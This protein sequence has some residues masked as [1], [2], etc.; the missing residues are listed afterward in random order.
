MP[1]RRGFSINSKRACGTCTP[2]CVKRDLPIAGVG[3]SYFEIH[4][5]RCLIGIRAATDA[6][7]RLL[8]GLMPGTEWRCRPI[9]ESGQRKFLPAATETCLVGAKLRAE[10]LEHLLIADQR[11]IQA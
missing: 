6:R 9:S 11:L 8:P 10:G 4:G 5:S 7:M 1:S 3:Q 2:H